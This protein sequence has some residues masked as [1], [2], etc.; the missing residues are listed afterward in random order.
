MG[1]RLRHG[2]RDDDRGIRELIPGPGHF[3]AKWTPVHVKK[4]RSNKNLVTFSDSMGSENAPDVMLRG[5]SYPRLKSLVVS[6]PRLAA[7]NHQRVAIPPVPPPACELLW[8]AIQNR[9]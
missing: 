6:A 8:P 7:I 3:Q 9:W 1:E 4:M 5:K 2:R